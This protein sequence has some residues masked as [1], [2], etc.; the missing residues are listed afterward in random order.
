MRRGKSTGTNEME[1]RGS[2]RRQGGE[3]GREDGFLTRN[4]EGTYERHHS[5][6]RRRREV[7][8]VTNPAFTRGRQG[9]QFMWRVF[10]FALRQPISGCCGNDDEKSL[11]CLFARPA[12]IPPFAYFRGSE[13]PMRWW[14]VATARAASILPRS[15]YRARARSL[16][17]LT[18]ARAEMSR[19]TG[20]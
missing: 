8:S 3:D 15:R 13:I 16:T 10:C 1:R 17:S 5:R 12:P 11:C 18:R 19:T 6:D 2:G 4:S 9:R 7:Q 20:R 14:R